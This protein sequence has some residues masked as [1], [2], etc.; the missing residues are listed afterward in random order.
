MTDEGLKIGRRIKAKRIAAAIREFGGTVD[1]ARR[2][3]EAE[4][5]MADKISRWKNRT[6]PVVIGPNDRPPSME[7]R[8]LV[9]AELASDPRDAVMIAR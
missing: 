9:I 7:T 3:T 1:D 2:L 8:A 6:V 4:W 5:L